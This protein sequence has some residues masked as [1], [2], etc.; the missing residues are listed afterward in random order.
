[1]I[2]VAPL[3]PRWKKGSLEYRCIVT[4]SVSTPLTLSATTKYH[5]PQTVVFCSMGGVPS[6]VVIKQQVRNTL[7]IER[8]TVIL[9]VLSSK[10]MF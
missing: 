9:C 3:P 5:K 1:M 8:N 2:L 10:M 6:N 7:P 4:T